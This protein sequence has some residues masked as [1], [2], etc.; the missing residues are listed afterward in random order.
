MIKVFVGTSDASVNPVI[1][2]ISICYSIESLGCT[3][4]NSPQTG[5]G[6]SVRGGPRLLSKGKEGWDSRRR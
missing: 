6:V 2:T 1:G 3:Y 4:T 5:S